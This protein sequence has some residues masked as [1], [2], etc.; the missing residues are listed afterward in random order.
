MLDNMIKELINK[1]AEIEKKYDTNIFEEVSKASDDEINNLKNW[2]ANHSQI[3]IEEYIELIKY[4]NGLSFNGLLIYSLDKECEYNIYNSNEEWW[5][6]NEEQQ[7]YIFFGDDSIS[8]YCVNKNTGKYFIL[9][10]P[11][12]NIMEEYGTF[13]ELIIEALNVC[14]N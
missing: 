5:C 13:N 3:N 4:I 14:L 10:K 11:G 1:I 2:F 9:D 6:D 7:Q 8:W 12:G